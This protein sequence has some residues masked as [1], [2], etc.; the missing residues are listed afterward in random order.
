M[1]DRLIA[2]QMECSLRRQHLDGV[3]PGTPIRDIVDRCRMWES[4]AE[5]TACWGAGHIP[6]RPL[7]VYLVD[8]VGMEGGPVSY[9]DDQDLLESLVQHLLPTPALSPP[10]VSPI[11]SEHEQFI[12]RLLGEEPP[13]RPLLPERTNLTDM[14]IL[15]QG[16]LPVGSLATE[17][18]P[19]GGGGCCHES[20]V[21]C[22]SCGESGHPASRCPAMD[23]TFPFLPPG[24]QADWTGDG[25]V[26]RPPQKGAD[27]CLE[28]NVV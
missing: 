17:H 2:G 3:E 14:E 4:P 16:L 27:R 13:L 22:F 5:D 11:P 12:Q 8:D 25:F 9:S 26:M 6:T 20:T 19:R 18:Q 23:D 28:G 24:W 15:L 21:M 7:P 1:H 10:N